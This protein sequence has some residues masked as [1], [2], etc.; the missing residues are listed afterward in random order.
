[1]VLGYFSVK[2]LIRESY[3]DARREATSMLKRRYYRNYILFSLPIAYPVLQKFGF[4]STVVFWGAGTVISWI[5]M[6]NP[7]I[8][9]TGCL[10][11]LL[12]DLANHWTDMVLL[13]NEDSYWFKKSLYLLWRSVT[14]SW[15]K[16]PFKK[17]SPLL[18]SF[19]RRHLIPHFVAATLSHSHP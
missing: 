5:L 6:D 18:G 7:N 1:M 15:E 12:K 10:S 17:N 9:V 3:T 14:L 19:S 4:R 2:S 16:M 11:V 8:R 13:N